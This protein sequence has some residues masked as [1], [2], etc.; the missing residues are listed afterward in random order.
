MTSS[1]F[2]LLQPTPQDL[3]QTLNEKILRRTSSIGGHEWHYRLTRPHHQKKWQM[4]SYQ[5]S[6][7]DLYWDFI[8]NIERLITNI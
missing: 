6:F 7:I 8:C 5:G 2:G 1:L 3:H 4:T